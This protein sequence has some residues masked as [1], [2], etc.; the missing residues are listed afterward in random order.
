MMQMQCLK[1]FLKDELGYPS[2][3]NFSPQKLEGNHQDTEKKS[4]ISGF[5]GGEERGQTRLKTPESIPPR[6]K[7][8]RPAARGHVHL[9]REPFQ[10][11]L[12]PSESAR[13][14]AAV[15]IRKERYKLLPASLLPALSGATR[16]ARTPTPTPN[17]SPA[18]P[19]PEGQGTSVG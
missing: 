13:R 18:L 11:N 6:A 7:Q 2:N 3:P 5:G 15:F 1:I 12:T 9:L 14:S 19:S 17:P 8:Q 10:R 4:Q 16:A